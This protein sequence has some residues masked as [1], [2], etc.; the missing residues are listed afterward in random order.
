MSPHCP[1]VQP[2]MQSGQRG[3]SRLT[4]CV[5]VWIRPQSFS[6]DYG[7]IE[8]LQQLDVHQ[9]EDS[10]A[11]ALYSTQSTME[12]ILNQFTAKEM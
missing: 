5:A 11:E 8:T 10:I 6:I 1:L 7:N 3:E 9:L 12:N 2:V 4:L